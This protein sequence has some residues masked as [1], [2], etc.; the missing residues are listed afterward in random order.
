MQMSST[1]GGVV[2]RPVPS[3]VLRSVDET[4]ASS[5]PPPIETR[6]V[7]LWRAFDD[8]QFPLF[9]P[10]SLLSL[11]FSF[12]PA[13]RTHC[14]SHK[15]REPRARQAGRLNSAIE[16]AVRKIRVFC[17]RL[18]TS[19]FNDLSF[20]SSSSS[21][22]SRRARFLMILRARCKIATSLEYYGSEMLRVDVT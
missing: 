2:H 4:L 8:F 3:R 22:A 21:N 19:E 5:R 10:P 14:V 15:A 20:F 12:D 11:S 6:R 7:L 18:T 17:L 16:T 13:G 1:C 9:F